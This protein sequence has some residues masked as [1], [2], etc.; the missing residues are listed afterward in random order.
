MPVF[1]Y[2]GF[3]DD[4]VSANG[5]VE[6]A[7]EKLAYEILQARGIAVFELSTA[8]QLSSK[9]L[10]WYR[11]DIKFGSGGLSFERQAAVAELL[12]TL[13]AS[14]VQAREAVRIVATSAETAD[15]RV[16]FDRIGQ[17]MEDGGSLSEAF[18]AE[19]QGFSPI[20]G[21]FLSVGEAANDSGSQLAE[22]AAFFRRQGAMRHKLI[23]AL[24]YPVIL[25]LGAICLLLVVVLYL[26]PNLAPLFDVVGSEPSG[27]L[28]L[29]IAA[30]DILRAFWLQVILSCV[31]AVIGGLAAIQNRALK[32]WVMKVVTKVP[33]LGMLFRFSELT[34][35]AHATRLLLQAGK[36]L[37]TALR[38][39]SQL[40]GKH[41]VFLGVFEDAARSLEEGND[42]FSVLSRNTMIPPLFSELF[43]IGEETNRLPSALSSLSDAMSAQVDHLTQRALA[44]MTPILTLVLGSGIG[45][46][47]YT[48]MGAILEV[49]EL[50]F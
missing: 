49:N 21:S 32:T 34:R 48:I 26:V 15:I 22:L 2:N 45:F 38:E 43:R 39:A 18:E 1:L 16:Q 41:S 13:F 11:R 19:N 44:L 6:A 33:L 5:G 9:S 27:A 7:T 40:A 23:S 17:R 37:P 4:G 50:A 30:N 46:L 42:A 12:A 35:I 10:P 29:L 47:I 20:F 24:I 31:L 3:D 25:L 8:K 36:P 28:G 14:R